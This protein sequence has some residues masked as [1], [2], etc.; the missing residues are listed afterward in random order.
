M[1]K[2]NF[3]YDILGRPKNR[4]YHNLEQAKKVVS[5]K[6]ERTG[7]VLSIEAVPRYPGRTV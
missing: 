2:V 3:G 4:Y 5:D 6:F 1:Y 7:V